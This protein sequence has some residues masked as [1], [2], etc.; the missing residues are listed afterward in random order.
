M[1]GCGLVLAVIVG[2][3]RIEQYGRFDCTRRVLLVCTSNLRIDGR[4]GV[5]SF[6]KYNQTIAWT[7]PPRTF[8]SRRPL[9]CPEISFP[10]Q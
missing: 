10:L 7:S 9:C 6:G 4:A 5:P 3:P 2:G 1:F 8:R